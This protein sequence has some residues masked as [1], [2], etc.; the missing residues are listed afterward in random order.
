MQLMC[1][2]TKVST[3]KRLD[4]VIDA[5]AAQTKI[6]H[7][8]ID[9]KEIDANDIP[10]LGVVPVVELTQCANLCEYYAYLMHFFAT[11]HDH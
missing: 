5:I 4:R 10:L 7:L 11:A 2:P 9:V 6:F 3:T 8:A 1:F